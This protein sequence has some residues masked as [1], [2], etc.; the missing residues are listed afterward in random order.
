MGEEVKNSILIVDDEKSNLKFLTR[1]LNVDYTIYT[2]KSGEDAIKKADKLLPDL[3]LLDILMPE[4]NGHEV[5]A[6]LK[7][8]KKTREIPVIFISALAS[9]EDEEKGLTLDA[10]DY[11]SKPFAPEVVK[12]RVRNQIQTVNQLRASKHLS[13]TDQLT[14]MPNRRSFDSHFSMEWA[15]A[16]RVKAPISILMLD[17]DKFKNFND[18]YGHEHGD[19]VLQAVAKTIMQTLKRPTDF[20][21]RWGGEEFIVLLRDTGVSGALELAE[22]IRCNIESTQIPC[23][24][25]ST[26]KVTISIGIAVQETMPCSCTINEFLSRADKALYTAKETG[27]NRVCLYNNRE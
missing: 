26:T 10:A 12:L 23:T 5:V 14:N 16:M 13:M 8:S 9:S 20:A 4:M 22:R 15:H 19:L 7:K 27:R 18:I 17:V 1:I 25:G 3:I 24:D 6:A 11:I 2:S 21:A